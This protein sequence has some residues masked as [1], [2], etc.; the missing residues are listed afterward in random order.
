MP[1]VFQLLACAA[2]VVSQAATPP[3]IQERLDRVKADLYS[4]TDRLAENVKELKEILALDPRS[5]DAHM[6]LGIAYSTWGSS[7]LKGEAI[8]EFRQALDLNP[9]LV[10]V[11]FF[12]AHLY[13]DLG[14]AARAREELDA[15]LAQTPGNPEFL[16]L[17]GEAE[18]Q[19]KNPA[20]AVEVTRQAL[21]ADE[22]FA[23]A[24][25]YLG[26]A[27]LD[28][29]KRDE[30]IAELEQVVRAG[31]GVTDTYL[32]LGNA[33]VDA[34]RSAD[35][36]ETLTRGLRIDTTRP[37][38]HIALARA[39][40]TKGML[41][42]AEAQLALGLPK[43][44]DLAASSDYPYQQVDLDYQLELAQLKL[45]RGQLAAAAQAFRKVLALEPTH[46]AATRGLAEVNRRLAAKKQG[47][48]R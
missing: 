40:R 1:G 26:L 33:Y 11:R 7:D 43:R 22:T 6:L 19:L 25:Y 27:L 28:L 29:G 10:Q 5:A 47:G 24:R 18:R 16:A 45:Q 8:G 34:G 44:A 38:L 41:V 36:I 17:L 2:L 21:K 15:G 14:R 48:A 32:T 12:L 35:A 20:R 42:K 37:E 46:D 23:Q 4:R 13:L 39:Y 30:A 9:R 3:P 31:P